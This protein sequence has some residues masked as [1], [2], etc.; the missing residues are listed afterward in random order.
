MFCI[1]VAWVCLVC[2]LL[3]KED[4]SSLV[5][6]QLLRGV[7][8]AYMR[9]HC[10]CLCGLWDGDYVSQLPSVWYYVVVMSICLRNVSSRGFMCFRYLMFSLSGHCELFLLLVFIASWT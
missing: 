7:R 4:G 8:W 1:C 10:L 5:S 9:C 2:L 6:L 3:C